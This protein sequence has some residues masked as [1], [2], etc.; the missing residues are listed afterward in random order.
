MA[1]SKARL[2]LAV[3]VAKWNLN[4][5]NEFNF[6]CT[7]LPAADAEACNK[8]KFLDDKK[9]ALVSRLLQRHA[10]FLALDIPHEAVIIERTKGRKPYVANKIERLHAPN[11]NYSVSHEVSTLSVIYLHLLTKFSG[12]SI[13]NST[14]RLFILQKRNPT[15]FFICFSNRAITLSWLQKISVSVDVTLQPLINYAVTPVNR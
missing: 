14:A 12:K 15:E 8:F 7:L 11:Y 9:R 2:R 4:N 5:P 13:D 6:L 10:A 3:N 1:Q